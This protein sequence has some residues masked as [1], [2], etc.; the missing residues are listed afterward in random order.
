MKSAAKINLIWSSKDNPEFT[1][2]LSRME[3]SHVCGGFTFLSY[4]TLP[5]KRMGRV[6]LLLESAREILGKLSSPEKVGFGTT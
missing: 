1:E 3:C 5:V 2:V 6:K 4:L